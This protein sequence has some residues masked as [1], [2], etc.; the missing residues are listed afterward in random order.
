MVIKAVESAKFR[1]FQRACI[2][3]DVSGSM[4]SNIQSLNHFIQ[5]IEYD[6]ISEQ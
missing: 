1:R 6:S 3:P 4:G 5:R 2:G